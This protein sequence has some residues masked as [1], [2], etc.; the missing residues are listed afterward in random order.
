MKHIQNTSFKSQFST[1]DFIILQDEEEN[2]IEN[3][4]RKISIRSLPTLI[5]V[6]MTISILVFVT[7]CVI[8]T[9]T[10]LDLNLLLWLARSR[11]FLSV[12]TCFMALALLDFWKFPL[13]TK[14]VKVF[15][16]AMGVA[17]IATF[18]LI[19]IR[20]V[21]PHY[22]ERKILLSFKNFFSLIYFKIQ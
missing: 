17:V 15:F 2:E 5:V 7:A 10:L 21:R 9:M 4:R 3:A 11:L 13:E 1:S 22:C 20:N 8:S 18:H 6:F 14:E 12:T 16:M 19:M